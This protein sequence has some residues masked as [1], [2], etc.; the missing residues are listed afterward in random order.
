MCTN[1]I[2]VVEV[3]R[4]FNK[5]NEVKTIV[6]STKGQHSLSEFCAALTII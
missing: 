1:P 2:S 6:R 5:L 4:S 3:E